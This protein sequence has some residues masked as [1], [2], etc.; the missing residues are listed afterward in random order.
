MKFNVGFALALLATRAAGFQ[1]MSKW[2][3]PLSAQELTDKAAMEERFGDKSKLYSIMLF[4]TFA[5]GEKVFVYTF[6]FIF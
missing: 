3:A 4:R 6:L 5:D 2:K 1:F